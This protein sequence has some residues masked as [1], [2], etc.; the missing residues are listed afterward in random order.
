MGSSYYGRFSK[1]SLDTALRNF[2]AAQSKN[3]AIVSINELAQ[4]FTS[5]GLDTSNIPSESA[6]RDI[7][8]YLVG[9]YES[10]GGFTCPYYGNRAKNPRRDRCLLDKTKVLAVMNG[11]PVKA[12][13]HKLPHHM[14]CSPP[15]S[16][17]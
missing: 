15:P 14:K 7:Y 17:R 16:K 3:N 1:E 6:T 5:H 8:T 4:V 2:M 11:E 13:N 10:T 12:K 9:I